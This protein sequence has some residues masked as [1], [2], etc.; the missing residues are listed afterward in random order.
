MTNRFRINKDGGYLMKSE[1]CEH[2][3]ISVKA[4]ID[5]LRIGGRDEEALVEY[6][7]VPALLK[8]LQDILSNHH[9]ENRDGR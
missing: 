8:L 6:Q 1:W 7:D 5:G 2:T 9:K 3:S 4:E